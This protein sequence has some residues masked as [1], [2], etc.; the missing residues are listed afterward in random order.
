MRRFS[1]FVIEAKLGALLTLHMFVR[2]LTLQQHRGVTHAIIK[3]RWRTDGLGIF[4]GAGLGAACEHGL[5]IGSPCLGGRGQTYP[6]R[7]TAAGGRPAYP[8]CR[9]L[10]MVRGAALGTGL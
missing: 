4:Q 6:K 1:L 9:T 10:G 7:Q 5:V 2:I 3:L 8:L